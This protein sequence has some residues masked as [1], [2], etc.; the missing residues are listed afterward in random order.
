MVYKFTK[1]AE[2]AIEIAS[3]IATEFGHSYIG[4]EHLLYGLVKEGEGVAYKVLENQGVTEEKILEEISLLVGKNDAI[5]DLV[6]MLT[7]GQTIG[8]TPRTKRVF[9]NAFREAKRTGLDYIGTEH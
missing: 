7:G 1:R 5:T 8:F 3:Q 4:T 9:E 6:G 2:K